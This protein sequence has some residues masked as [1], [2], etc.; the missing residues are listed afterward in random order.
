MG[1]AWQYAAT[2]M[3]SFA[4]RTHLTVTSFILK[5]PHSVD[6]LLQDAANGHVA[7]EDHVIDPM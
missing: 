3:H 2:P 1:K 7:Q 6:V 4:N 5:G